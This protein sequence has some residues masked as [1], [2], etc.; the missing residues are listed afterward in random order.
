M[1]EHP[2]H[3]LDMPLSH[4]EINGH[5]VGGPNFMRGSTISY[6]NRAPGVPKII[7]IWGPGSP[8]LYEIELPVDTPLIHSEIN[9]HCVGGPIFMRGS[10]ISYENK[11]PVDYIN[12]GPWVHKFIWN[13][14]PRVPKIGSPQFHMTPVIEVQLSRC[15]CSRHSDNNIPPDWLDVWTSA[16]VVLTSSVKS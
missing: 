14:G 6:E 15:R 13:W 11:A 3:P 12:L 1:L 5:C 2:E 7:L 8:S 10:L 9:G 4:S 16:H